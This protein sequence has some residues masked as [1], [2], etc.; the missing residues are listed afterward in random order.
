LF[1]QEGAGPDIHFTAGRVRLY[2]Y[3]IRVTAKTPL[4]AD[5]WG[6]IAITRSGT[7]LKVYVNGIEDATGRWGGVLNIKAIGRGNRGYYKGMMDEIRIWDIARSEAEISAGYE[8]E[9]EPNTLRLIGYW[10]FNGTEQIISDNSS[11]QNNGSLGANTD[12]GTDDPIRLDVNA[13]FTEN[14]L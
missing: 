6:H 4:I 3:G 11:S 5:T 8:A 2:V 12:I 1:G 13:P 14:C 9:V 7:N 10:N